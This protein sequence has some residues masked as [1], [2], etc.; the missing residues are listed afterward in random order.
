[1]LRGTIPKHSKTVNNIAAAAGIPAFDRQPTVL[2]DIALTV[3][4]AIP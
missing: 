2:T 4:L 3:S 1:V